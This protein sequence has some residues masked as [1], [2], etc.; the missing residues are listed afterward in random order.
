MVILCP[1]VELRIR[2]GSL[3]DWVELNK[4]LDN[5]IVQ[6]PFWTSDRTLWTVLNPE[7]QQMQPQ[8]GTLWENRVVFVSVLGLRNQSQLAKTAK[9]IEPTHDGM[10]L[11]KQTCIRYIINI[12]GGLCLERWM[13]PLC[14]FMPNFVTFGPPGDFG[15]LASSSVVTNAELIWE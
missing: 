12:H 3:I 7:A 11:K 1:T 13:R 9:I 5:Q 14:K 6:K 15:G 4:N 2:L 10:K 8:I